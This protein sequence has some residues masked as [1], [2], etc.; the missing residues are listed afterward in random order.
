M[1]LSNTN[2]NHLSI[3]DAEFDYLAFSPAAFALY[4]QS[5]CYQMTFTGAGTNREQFFPIWQQ[6]RGDVRLHTQFSHNMFDFE[7]EQKQRSHLSN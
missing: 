1:S 4:L 5:D 6:S 2:Y 7:M 3:K